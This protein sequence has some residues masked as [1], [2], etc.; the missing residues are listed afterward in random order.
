MA[1]RCC[2]S[3]INQLFFNSGI[4][5]LFTGVMSDY[6]VLIMAGVLVILVKLS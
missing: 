3:L 6:K 2:P 4:G 5:S 1:V